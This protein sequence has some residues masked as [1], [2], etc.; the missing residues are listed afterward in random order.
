MGEYMREPVPRL[1]RVE[2][3]SQRVEMVGI[4]EAHRPR[5]VMQQP[6]HLHQ[7]LLLLILILSLNILM[8]K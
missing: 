6:L 2:T 3:E 8:T 7:R 4:R 5:I 1:G